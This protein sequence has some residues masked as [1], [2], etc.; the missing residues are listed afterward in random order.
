MDEV[1]RMR[2]QNNFSIQRDSASP[3]GKKLTVFNALFMCRNCA[4]ANTFNYVGKISTFILKSNNLQQKDENM[5]LLFIY[6]EK[7][8]E[9]TFKHT[10]LHCKSRIEICIKMRKHM[11]KHMPI[12]SVKSHREKSRQF[13]CTSFMITESSTT[14]NQLIFLKSSYRPTEGSSEQLSSYCNLVFRQDSDV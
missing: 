9:V 3:V 11:Q 7:S 8:I 2:H 14:G 4:G 12:L 6:I 5:N 1:F 13:S 10:Y